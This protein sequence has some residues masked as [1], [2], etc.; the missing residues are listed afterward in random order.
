MTKVCLPWHNY[1][2][3]DEPFVLTN[4]CLSWQRF[5]LDKHTFVATKDV[6]CHDKSTL[7]VAKLLSWQYSVCWGKN[8]LWQKFCC[9]KHNFFH[10]K[11]CHDKHTFVMT[12]EVFC[13]DK[14]DTCGSS[15]QQYFSSHSHQPAHWLHLFLQ[16]PLLFLNP[17]QP[18]KQLWVLVTRVRNRWTQTV[19]AGIGRGWRLKQ[20]GIK[21]S[22]Y[23]F[24]AVCVNNTAHLNI[25]LINKCSFPPTSISTPK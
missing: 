10:G 2:S 4:T 14:N 18:P 16:R 8:L 1:V 24:V 21:P 9:E 7:V 15:R 19:A 20:A 11:T 6:F 23:F 12:K 17:C 22:A 5:C 3:R 13:P 25:K